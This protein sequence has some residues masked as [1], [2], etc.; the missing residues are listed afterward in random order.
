MIQPAP[1]LNFLISL[2]I[3]L[4]SSLTNAY[5]PNTE[6]L[7]PVLDRFVSQN[8]AED[9]THNAGLKA[10]QQFYASRNYQPAWT[11]TNLQQS[12]LETVLSFLA[13]AEDEGLDSHDYQLQRLNLLA[14]NP[15]HSQYEL[16]FLTT[17]S[18]L[19]FTHD[20]YRGRFTANKIDPDW[21]ISQPQFDAVSFLSKA[22]DSND[23][24]HYLD[25]LTPKIPSYRLLKEA[26]AKYRNLVARQISW[27]HIPTIQLLRPGDSHPVIPLIRTR[28]AQAY[29]THGKI[30]YNLAFSKENENSNR[31]DPSLVNAIKAFQLQ[32]GLNADG[33]IGKNTLSALNKAPLEKVKQLRINMERLRWLPRNL[34]ERYVLVNIAGFQLA[35]IED[36]QYI[37]DMRIIVGRNYRSTPSF[38]SRITHMII[39]PYWNVPAS[40]ARKDL[41]PKQQKDPDYFTHHNIKVYSSY[42]YNPDPIDPDTIDWQA[43]RGSFPY[44]LRQDPGYQNALGTIKFML[45]NRFSIYLHDTPS[46]E[47]FDKDIRTFSSGCI[48]LEKPLQL[49]EFALRDRTS[50][51]T[52]KEHI[53]SGKTMQINLPEPLP[54]YIVYLT[55]WVDSQHNIHYSP[56]TY[57]RDKRALNFSHW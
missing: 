12:Q 13:T 21:H 53:S 26:L 14:T 3:I 27:Q 50:I 15:L 38:N 45:P 7:R 46:K 23:L 40:I 42:A 55:A 33:I 47:L 28:I 52:L 31:Y 20:L 11:H 35:A 32:H 9:I 1:I 6:T 41:L 25:N 10:L 54:T 18:L 24:Q 43:I 49:A 30:E 57:G 17:L 48:R 4:S 29:E 16:E 56:D 44:A 5:S 2:V 19:Q 37:L 8:L 22:I 51:E 39:N 34:G 36:D